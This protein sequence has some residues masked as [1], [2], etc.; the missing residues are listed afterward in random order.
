MQRRDP[1]MITWQPW[2]GKDAATIQFM[3]DSP[4]YQN[5]K[6]YREQCQ[7]S[8]PQVLSGFMTNQQSQTSTVQCP[9]QML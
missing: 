9:E 4:A 1:K 8:N 2:W 7:H 3:L 6:T 5:C